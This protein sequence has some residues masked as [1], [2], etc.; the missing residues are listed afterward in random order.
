MLNSTAIQFQVGKED[1]AEKKRRTMQAAKTLP[2]SIKDKRIPWAEPP[3]IPF[4]KRDKER[5]N[6]DQDTSSRPCLILRVEVLFQE[7]AA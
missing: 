2:T 7:R 1:C 6:V 5:V 3:C 4:T